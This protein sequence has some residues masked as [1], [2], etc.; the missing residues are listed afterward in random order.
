MDV[1]AEMELNSR[2][3][4]S[5]TARR[6]LYFFFA[7]TFLSAVLFLAGILRFV[8]A[9]KAGTLQIPDLAILLGLGAAAFC[10]FLPW[11]M[12]TWVA[13]TLLHRI[14]SLER[15]IALLGGD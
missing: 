13:R 3:L 9:E 8:K 1:D 5:I 4:S 7:F 10:L 6:Y 12:I 14:Q 11:L 15:A 2:V